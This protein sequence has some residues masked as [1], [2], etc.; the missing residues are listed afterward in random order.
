MLT[1]ATPLLPVAD[2]VV[3][4]RADL[5]VSSRY[6]QAHYDAGYLLVDLFDADG[7]WR[8]SWQA[9]DSPLLW[10]ANPDRALLRVKKGNESVYALAD[11]HGTALYV[12][13]RDV[14]WAHRWERLLS[15]N[16][17]MQSCGYDPVSYLRT[18]CI[19]INFNQ[20]VHAFDTE[21]QNN[22]WP[23]GTFGKFVAG[24]HGVSY[25]GRVLGREDCAAGDL[26]PSPSGQWVAVWYYSVANHGECVSMYIAKPFHGVSDA[27]HV[28]LSV[29]QA[30]A[31]LAV[32][33]QES[34]PVS[35]D[36]RWVAT[37]THE[38]HVVRAR[39][40]APVASVR[41]TEVWWHPD[42]HSYLS[43]SDGTIGIVEI[44]GRRRTL[45]D[46][47]CMELIGWLGDSVVYLTPSPIEVSEA[48]ESR[49]A[50]EAAMALH[51]SAQDA[52]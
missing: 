18:E 27:V 43:R 11:P 3:H 40:D 25:D 4:V 29:E 22:P 50:Y 13:S 48:Y 16:R 32:W 46:R 12:V 19:Y 44:D 5:P 17:V 26:L 15:H 33:Q 37:P 30:E 7:N 47:C 20:P 23:D 42:G 36:G 8:T 52:E 9:F 21:R 38:S 24:F 39:D 31:M 1:L 41:E 45:V 28:V 6:D 10:T 51:E 14:G 35:P 34:S 2:S 49:E